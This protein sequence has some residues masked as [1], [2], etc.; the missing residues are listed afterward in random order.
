MSIHEKYIKRC[1]QLAKNGFGTTYPNPLVGS[2][3]VHNNKIIGEGWHYQAGKP[4]AEV[5]AINSVSDESI[6]K[7]ATIYVS[8]EPCSHYGKTPPCSDLIIEKGIKKVVIGTIDP[9]AK[10][11]GAGIQKLMNAGCDVVVGVLEKE[12]QELNKRFFTFHTK[13]RPYIILKWAETLNGF[14]APESMPERKP[15]WIT[16]LYSRQL[17]HKWRAEE[18]AI[19]VGSKT[20]IKDNPKLTIR[21][22]AGQHPIRIVIDRSDQIPEDSAILDQTVKTIIITSSKHKKE[23]SNQLIYE[24]VNSDNNLIEEVCAILYK[25]DIQ[26]VI[27]EGGAKTLQAFINQNVWDEARVFIGKTSFGSGIKAPILKR[28]LISEDKIMDDTLRI[29]YND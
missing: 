27:I 1:V 4:H 25:H 15:I 13:K 2:V 10:V 23:S 5:N 16:N 22:W 14:I 7:D 28:D 11:C 8:L 26:S 3:I 12:C 17:V 6:L 19:V 18:Q 24:N 29:Y 20:V 21:D 9:F